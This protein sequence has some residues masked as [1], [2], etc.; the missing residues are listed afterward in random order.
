MGLSVHGADNQQLMAKPGFGNQSTCLGQ[1]PSEHIDYQIYRGSSN[2][3]LSLG[4]NLEPPLFPIQK[5]SLNLLR[6]KWESSDY[7]RSECCPESSRFRLLQLQESKLLE[8]K[9]EEPS[10]PEPLHPSRLPCRA[11]EETVSTEPRE[12]GP[13]H[14]SDHSR[15]H[16]RPEVLKEDSLTSRRRIERF[17][18]ALDEL[19]SVFEAPK[20]EDKPVGPAEYDRKVRSYTLRVSVYI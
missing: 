15:E 3:C 8:P 19:R 20:S 18:I 12:K 2:L 14:K 17:S 7:Q 9:G 13:E 11:Q 16:S 10:A 1:R 4:D 5:G 6:Q